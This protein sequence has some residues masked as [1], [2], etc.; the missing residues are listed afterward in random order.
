MEFLLAALEA[1]KIEMQEVTKRWNSD[2]LSDSWLSKNVRPITLVYLLSVMLTLIILDSFIVELDVKP[3]W[4]ALIKSLL[5]IVFGGY[6]GA[7]SVEMV[8]KIVK[9]R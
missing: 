6:S 2:V 1:D 9:G 8:M 4:V 5:L 3:N 7:R